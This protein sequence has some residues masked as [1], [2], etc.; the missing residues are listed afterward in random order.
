MRPFERK[1]IALIASL[2]TPVANLI[3]SQAL[4]TPIPLAKVEIDRMYGGWYIVATI[5][6]SF[7]KGI[8]AP[9]DLPP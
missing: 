5:P 7:E 1:T 3:W 8:V 9:Y 4:A 6:N 2:A